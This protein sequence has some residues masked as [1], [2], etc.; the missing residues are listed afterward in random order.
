MSGMTTTRIKAWSLYFPDRC[1]ER[2]R[3]GACISSHHLCSKIVAVNVTA[4]GQTQLSR[5]RFTARF[6][7][8]ANYLTLDQTFKSVFVEE[9]N[10]PTAYYP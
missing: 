2:L 1:R 4:L 7:A 5:V 9:C 6:S 10:S 3:F 8:V